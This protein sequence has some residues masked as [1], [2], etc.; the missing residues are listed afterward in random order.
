MAAF[1]AKNHF[2]VEIFVCNQI[3]YFHTLVTSNGLVMEI[4]V[5]SYLN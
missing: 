4:K 2:V 3:T 1:A 5:Y